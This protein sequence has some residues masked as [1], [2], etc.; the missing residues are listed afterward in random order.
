MY[1]TRTLNQNYY[2]DHTY[3]K[4]HTNATQWIDEEIYDPDLIHGLEKLSAAQ[5]IYL[6]L[7]NDPAGHEIEVDTSDL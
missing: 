4:G 3:E 1:Y 5:P 2:E 6:G 7:I